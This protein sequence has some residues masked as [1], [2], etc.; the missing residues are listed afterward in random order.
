MQRYAITIEY[1]GT[2]FSG[3][4]RQTENLSIQWVIEQA[5]EVLAKQAVPTIVAGRTD[6]GVHARGQVFH[7]D[8]ALELSPQKLCDALNALVRPH[9]ISFLA[10]RLVPN[11]F[12]A[13]LSAIQRHYQYRILN[14]RA[15]AML[16]AKRVWQIRN[17]LNL[18]AMQQAAQALLGQHD[19]TSFRDSN[20]QA[21]SPIRILDQLDLIT[22]GEYVIAEISARA[23]LHHQVRNMIG[24]LVEIGNGKRQV[25]DIPAILAAKDR[26]AGRANCTSLRLVFYAGRLPLALHTWAAAFEAVGHEVEVAEYFM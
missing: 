24:T 4:Q 20:C 17:R 2:P 26:R 9:P 7:C 25:A 19:F 15:P 21:K 13:R 8:L 1:D 3:W 16:E 10:A 12:S 22:N 23:F 14:R 6:A 11:D 18:P 5:L